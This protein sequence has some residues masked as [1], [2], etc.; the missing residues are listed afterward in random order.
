MKKEPG[1]SLHYEELPACRARMCL[2]KKEVGV[3]E[4]R[5]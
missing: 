1:F 2:F 3:L 4:G 5:G